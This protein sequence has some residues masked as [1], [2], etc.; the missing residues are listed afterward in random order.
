MSKTSQQIGQLDRLQEAE[1]LLTKVGDVSRYSLT[2]L[3]KPILRSLC[4]KYKIEIRSSG[5]ANLV[6]DY[7]DAIERWV[8]LYLL[9]D[10]LFKVFKSNNIM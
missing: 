3:T 6:R 8:S 2:K 7:V 1:I 4:E 9:A 10:L 5:K